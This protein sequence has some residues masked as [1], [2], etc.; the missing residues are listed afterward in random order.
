MGELVNEGIVDQPGRPNTNARDSLMAAACTSL[1]DATRD[2]ER[3]PGG[4][5]RDIENAVR[6][7]ISALAAHHGTRFVGPNKHVAVVR[8][9]EVHP[10]FDDATADRVDQIRV[11]RNAGMY[12]ERNE[13][14]PVEYSAGDAAR[15]VK[16][17]TGVV[18][19]VTTLLNTGRP[20]PP[21]PDIG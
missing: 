9:V 11:A 19:R 21:P 5:I 6:Q 2:Q 18:N 12:G 15:L 17:G 13:S 20:I 4:M 8:F 3:S 10:G 16:A 7:A 1:A 14:T